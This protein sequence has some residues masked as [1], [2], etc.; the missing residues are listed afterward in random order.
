MSGWRHSQWASWPTGPR[1]KSHG[2]CLT[3]AFDACSRLIVGASVCR[4]D[5]PCKELVCLADGQGILRNAAATVP[6]GIGDALFSYAPGQGVGGYLLREPVTVCLRAGFVNE[7]AGRSLVDLGCR[8]LVPDSRLPASRGGAER[9]MAA[10]REALGIVIRSNGDSP[11]DLE[12]CRTFAAAVV[13][14]ASMCTRRR[15]GHA[16]TRAPQ[17]SPRRA[18]AGSGGKDNIGKNKTL[19][20]GRMP[21]PTI[22]KPA[23][24]ATHRAAPPSSAEPFVRHPAADRALQALAGRL[25]IAGGGPAG[26]ARAGALVIVGAPRS[27]KTALLR[28]FARQH[29]RPAAS[30]DDVPMPVLIVDV[31]GHAGI[32]ALAGA[33]AAALGARLPASATVTECFHRVTGELSRRNVRALMLDDAHHLFHGNGPAGCEAAEWALQLSARGVCSVVLAGLPGALAAPGRFGRGGKDVTDVICLDGLRADD[34][35]ERSCFLEALGTFRRALPDLEAGDALDEGT[36]MKLLEHCGG[37]V[38]RLSEFLAHAAASAR[39]KGSARLTRE[40][41]RSAAERTRG[42]EEGWQNPFDPDVP[43]PGASPAAPRPVKDGGAAAADESE[44]AARG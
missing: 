15:S 11:V 23:A 14:Y 29:G 25:A 30:G 35:A 4:A 33:V 18:R 2:A 41:L 8:V 3:V 1:G 17:A 44:G 5:E 24:A 9:V 10:I 16:A 37:L 19:G 43:E 6:D 28:E 27:G 21:K 42:A 7:A 20:A 31:P 34:R 12:R 26:S 36:A 32:K 38:G 22:T 39:E 40:V 13:A